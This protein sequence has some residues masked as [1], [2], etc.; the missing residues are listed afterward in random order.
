[1][2]SKDYKGRCTKKKLSK[3]KDVARLYDKI[4]ITY[5]DVLEADKAMKEIMCNVPLDNLPEGEYTSDFVCV[6]SDGDY[7]VR[8]CVWK[9]KLTLPR[10]VKLLDASRSYWAK[11]GV[12]DWGIVIEKEADVGE[13]K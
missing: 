2:I 13:K 3:C 7:M 1:M 4:Q 12:T 5:A 9:K 8:E 10:T 6:K 11:R